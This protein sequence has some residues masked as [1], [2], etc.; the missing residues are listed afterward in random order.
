MNLLA[1]STS[2]HPPILQYSLQNN[3]TKELSCANLPV[4]ML[5]L[6]QRLTLSSSQRAKAIYFCC[7]Q[8]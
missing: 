3:A 6:L 2:G 1:Y 7:A 8:I 4:G 5:S